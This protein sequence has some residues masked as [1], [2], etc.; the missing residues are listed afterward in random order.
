MVIG[1]VFVLAVIL[2]LFVE[3]PERLKGLGLGR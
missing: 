2:H 3:K 1:V